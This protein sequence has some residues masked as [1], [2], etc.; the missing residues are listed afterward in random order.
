MNGMDYELCVNNSC[1]ASRVTSTRTDIKSGVERASQLHNNNTGKKPDIVVIYMGTNDVGNSI[2]LQT[3]EAAYIE[4]LDIVKTNYPAADVYCCTLLP[5]SRTEGRIDE[6]EA[7]NE[8]IC[9]IT[10]SAGYTVID[11]YSEIPD[12][13]YTSDTFVDGT[14]RVHPTATGMDKL[15]DVVIKAL[16]G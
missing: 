16:K 7:Y 2:A 5:E 14:L 15:S 6:L 1:D 10:T 4:M 11:F 12:W 3:F 13:D 9:S 8:S